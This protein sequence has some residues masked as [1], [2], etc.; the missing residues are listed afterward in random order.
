VSPYTLISLV[1]FIKNTSPSSAFKFSLQHPDLVFYVPQKVF[2]NQD[3]EDETYS[4][5][6]NDMFINLAKEFLN[7]MLVQKPV[8]CSLQDGIEVLD[9]LEACR[10]SHETQKVV[11]LN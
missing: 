3:W 2:A 10:Q 1:V 11:T 7:V 8:S 5:E 9:I 6:R 4:Y